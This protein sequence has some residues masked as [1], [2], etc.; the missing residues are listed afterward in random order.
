MSAMIQRW[1]FAVTLDETQNR[2]IEEFAC[3]GDWLNRYEYLIDL[4]KRLDS[5]PERFRTDA[6]A[7]PGCQ[8][9][10]W[11][12]AEL[13]GG[14]L[15]F[16]ADSDSLII[17]GILALLLRAVDNQPPA[18]IAAAK[19]YFLEEIGL[20]ANLSPNRANGVST[21][22]QHLRDCGARYQ[23]AATDARTS[24]SRSV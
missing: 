11:I 13:T 8:S 9:Q 14:N 4:G 15:R 22:I 6:H 2:M 19:L 7:L 12:R 23:N 18:A 20:T 21:I 17:K 5:L 24:D 10:V 3:L 1:E 16:Q